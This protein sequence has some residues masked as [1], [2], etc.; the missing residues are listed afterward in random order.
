MGIQPMT[1]EIF[2]LQIKHV[3]ALRLGLVGRLEI[4]CRE[5]NSRYIFQCTV[6]GVP[7]AGGA[8]GLEKLDDFAFNK[9][10]EFITGVLTQEE[11]P[12]DIDW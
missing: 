5:T 6:D 3:V 11:A 8:F 7:I 1:P 4:N 2:T 9:G 10:T 12:Y